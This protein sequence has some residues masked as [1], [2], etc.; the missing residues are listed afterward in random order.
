MTRR[1]AFAIGASSSFAI[2]AR[3]V[4][5][6]E[7]RGHQRDKKGAGC[8]VWQDLVDKKFAKAR[9][10]ATIRCAGARPPEHNR[11]SKSKTPRTGERWR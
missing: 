4:V 3:C 9:L 8:P 1:E 11:G 10:V 5:C 7:Y 2:I 6:A